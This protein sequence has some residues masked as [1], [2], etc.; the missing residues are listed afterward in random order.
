MI[1]NRAGRSRATTAAGARAFP[2]PVWMEF[3]DPEAVVAAW[4]KPDVGSYG[5]DKGPDLLCDGK[6]VWSHCHS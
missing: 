3:A 6:V 2:R 4:A 1:A 5:H